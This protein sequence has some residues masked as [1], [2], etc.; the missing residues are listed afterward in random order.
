MNFANLEN[1]IPNIKII[2]IYANETSPNCQPNPIAA[3][4]VINTNEIVD[5]KTGILFDKSP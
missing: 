4:T 3:Q 1:I 5:T 2:G